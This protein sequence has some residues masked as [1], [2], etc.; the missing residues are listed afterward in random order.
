[1]D[2]QDLIDLELNEE[3]VTVAGVDKT[4]LTASLAFLVFAF[5][6][7]SVIVY[8][9]FQWQ[10]GKSHFPSSPSKKVKATYFDVSILLKSWTWVFPDVRTDISETP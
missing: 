7:I 5:L 2:H 6:Y 10:I 1:M 3:S 8:F 9:L 4:C